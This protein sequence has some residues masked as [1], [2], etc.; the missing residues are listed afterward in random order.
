MIKN[1]IKGNII[2]I[3]DQRIF[4]LTPYSMTKF[5]L[6]GLTKGQWH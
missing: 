1:K 2:N 3:I 6:E 4:K 5:G